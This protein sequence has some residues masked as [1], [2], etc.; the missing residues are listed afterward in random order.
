LTHGRPAKTLAA[1]AARPSWRD[2]VVASRLQS[3]E[4]VTLAE[5]A[6]VAVLSGDEDP[7]PF[8]DDLGSSA[9]ESGFAFATA[10]LAEHGLHDLHSVVG[11]LA[12]S[13][14]V[15]RGAAKRSG[16]VVALDVFVAKH[17]RRSEERFEEQADAEGLTGELRT[18]GREYIAAALGTGATRK[19]HAWLGGRDVTLRREELRPLSHRTAKRALVAFTRLVRALGHRGLRVVLTDAE[20]LIELPTARRDVAY[21]V[22][23]EMIDNGDGRGMVAC[24]VLLIGTGDLDRRVH[25]LLEHPALATRIVAD[26]QP[27]PPIPHQTWV[28]LAETSDLPPV[29]EVETKS[30]RH[31]ANLRALVRLMQGL[32]PIEAVPELTIGMEEVDRRIQ[33]LFET[34]SNDGSVFAVLM[35]DYGA[36]KT[37]HLLHFEARALADHRPVLR[38]AVERLDEDLGN[39]QRHLRRLIENAIAPGKRATDFLQR[40]E[41]WLAKAASRKRLAEALIA[42]RDSD[43]D[44]ARAATDALGAYEGE[45]DDDTVIAVLGALDLVAK[46]NA[47]AYRKDAYSRLQLWVEL[48]ARL[49]GCEG[50]VVILDEAENLY[51]AGVSR[52]V[53]RTALR[54]LAHYCGGA[55]PRA[56]V[57]LAVTPDTLEALREEA[58]ELLDEIEEQATLLPSE[59]VAMLRRRLLRARPIQVTKLGRPDLLLLAE[60]AQKLARS[61]W[62]RPIPKRRDGVSV[63]DPDFVARALRKS[64]T[65]RELLRVVLQEEARI[66]W[67]AD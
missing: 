59:D 35:G 55:I 19:L 46:P 36:G 65:P 7:A 5:I 18:L 44:A 34:A 31:A 50:P 49:E 30:D 53:R 12:S 6:T 37:H 33:Q 63:P 64:D 16:L 67:I 66:A 14:R 4:D 62:G 23:R 27:G 41:S 21:T 57:V 45:L 47:A 10:S 56:T 52:A 3:L 25:S 24:E 11:A 13:L 42:I 60:R 2:H 43:S 1:M 8:V 29:P 54:S 32:P 20:A 26:V 17:G 40:L 51:R 39:P 9:L 15:P 58:A 22:L 38:L 28:T 61:V 48:L